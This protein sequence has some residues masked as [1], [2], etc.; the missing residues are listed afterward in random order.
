MT[1][2]ETIIETQNL[3]KYFGA[4]AAV[5]DVSLKIE[6]GTLHAIIGPNGAGKTTFFNM[7]SG[8]LKPT[9]GKVFYKG[10]DLTGKPIHRMIHLGIGRSFQITNIFPN[11]TVHENIRLASQAME[12]NNFHF[13]M[14]TAKMVR[15]EE[16]TA[17]V[18]ERVGLKSQS[19]LPARALSHGDQRKL[20]LGM[21]LAPD[22]E[23]LLL[24]EPTAGMAT[25][26]VPELITLIQEVQRSGTKTVILVEHNMN[27][28]MSVSDKITV[29]HQGKVLAEGTPAEI[30]ANHEVQ[31][32]YLGGLY[33]LK[34]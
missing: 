27:V 2:R 22:P 28:V 18:I 33:D 5:D 8:N 34:V 1:V 12:D 24:D 13:L 31:T 30:A 11:L 10:M 26:Q 6:A 21:I 25:D 4:L 23:V 7:L 29:M 15:C 14:D 32:A 16:R 20:E 17:E 9:S 19:L 3:T